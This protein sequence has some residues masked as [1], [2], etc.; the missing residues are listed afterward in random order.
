MPVQAIKSN[1]YADAKFPV[2]GLPDGSLVRA[3]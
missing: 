1:S 2:T 3:K